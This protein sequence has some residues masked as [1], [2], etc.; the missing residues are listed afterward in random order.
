MSDP[1]FEEAVAAWTAHFEADLGAAEAL[2]DQ[3]SRSGDL[4]DRAK[5]L[6]MSVALTP[7]E[8]RCKHHDDSRYCPYCALDE[9]AEA[10]PDKEPKKEPEQPKAQQPKRERKKQPRQPQAELRAERKKLQAEIKAEREKLQAE[11]RGKD[12]KIRRQA[13]AIE[14]QSGEIERLRR[15]LENLQAQIATRGAK[16]GRRKR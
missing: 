8:Y 16:R 12:E 10:E 5:Q 13:E 11:L 3:V 6:G 14:F 1:S 2:R 15:D 7:R 4:A 9:S